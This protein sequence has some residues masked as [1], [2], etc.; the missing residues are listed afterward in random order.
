MAL[1]KVN[2]SSE[3]NRDKGSTLITFHLR[4]LQLNVVRLS[5]AYRSVNFTVAPSFSR[6]S[7]LFALIP[8]STIF[9][10]CLLIMTPPACRVAITRTPSIFLKSYFTWD[11]FLEIHFCVIF[12]DIQNFFDPGTPRISLGALIAMSLT[13]R[14]RWSTKIFGLPTFFRS[15]SP[16]RPPLKFILPI[17]TDALL[18][19]CLGYFNENF[20]MA[21]QAPNIDSCFST[22]IFKFSRIFF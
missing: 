1:W 11:V 6:M 3:R 16:S 9:K 15:T 14:I 13:F 2:F 20:L 19:R 17:Y 7:G 5:L 10:N 18:K 22:S 8:P 21:K 12:Q 4:L